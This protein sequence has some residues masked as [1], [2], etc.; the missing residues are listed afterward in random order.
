MLP[1]NSTAVIPFPSADCRRKNVVIEIPNRGGNGHPLTPDYVTIDQRERRCAAD[2][3]A[4]SALLNSGVATDGWSEFPFMAQDDNPIGLGMPT[5]G[6]AAI[7][8]AHMLRDS[9]TRSTSLTCND[10]QRS[11]TRCIT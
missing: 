6:T 5:C 9:I 3:V 11:A 4:A 7:A 8:T 1:S 2:N 10:L